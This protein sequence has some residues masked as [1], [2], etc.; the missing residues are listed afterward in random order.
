MAWR[1]VWRDLWNNK[2]RTFLVVLATTVGI[3]A[4]GVSFREG[5]PLD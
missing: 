1:K 4:L 3:F 5:L 2:L